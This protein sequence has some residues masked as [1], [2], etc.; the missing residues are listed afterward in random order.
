MV[1]DALVGDV[2]FLVEGADIGVR[3]VVRFRRGAIRRD[4]MT[5][6][7]RAIDDV[8]S[9]VRA[10]DPCELGRN[11]RGFRAMTVPAELNSTLDTMNHPLVEW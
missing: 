7:R 2:F 4:R 9:R 8:V 3:V 6:I 1:T 5:F 11:T 10:L